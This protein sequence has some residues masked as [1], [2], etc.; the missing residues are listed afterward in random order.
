MVLTSRTLLLEVTKRRWIVI[1]ND[2]KDIKTSSHEN[3][4]PR[5]ITEVR[6]TQINALPLSHVF[7]SSRM[8]H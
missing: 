7:G 8:T 4:N 3:P 5:L 2:V 1:V 6:A